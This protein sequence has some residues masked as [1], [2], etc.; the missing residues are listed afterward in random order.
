M[1]DLT[2]VTAEGVVVQWSEPAGQ[3]QTLWRGQSEECIEDYAESC[4]ALSW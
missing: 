4:A 1:V 3:W 2:C